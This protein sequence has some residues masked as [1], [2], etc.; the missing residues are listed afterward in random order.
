MVSAIYPQRMAVE[1]ENVQVLAF[2]I[3]I[4]MAVIFSVGFVVMVFLDSGQLHEIRLEDKINPNYASVASLVR[5]PGI[6]IARAEAIVAYRHTNDG[7]EGL[8][9]RSYDDLQKVKGIGPKTAQS[10]SQWLKFE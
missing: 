9:F 4:C 7:N 6:G 3:S 2:V 10:L 1:Q 5:L 8:V